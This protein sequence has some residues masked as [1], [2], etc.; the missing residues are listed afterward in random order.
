MEEKEEAQDKRPKNTLDK[1]YKISIIC[2][3]GLFLITKPI[4]LYNDHK[5]FV[6]LRT[7]ASCHLMALEEINE[8]RNLVRVL[9]QY[10]K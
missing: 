3:V 7:I 1:V 10:L 8:L 9:H 6:E 2:G 4:D 5:N